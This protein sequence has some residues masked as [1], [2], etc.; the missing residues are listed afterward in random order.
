M[1]PWLVDV[2]TRQ[3]AEEWLEGVPPIPYRPVVMVVRGDSETIREFIP[4]ALDAAKLDD[5]RV[6]LW[7]RDPSMAD[8]ARMTR[9]FADDDAAIAAVLDEDNELAARVNGDRIEVADA[10][11]AFDVAQGR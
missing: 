9:L 11:F 6:V 4:N 5:R 8:E 10:V 2:Q 3:Q 7:I 1:G